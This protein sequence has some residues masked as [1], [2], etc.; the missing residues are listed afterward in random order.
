MDYR[1]ES[2]KKHA[3]WQGKIEITARVPVGSREE[4]SLAYTPGVAEPCMAIHEDVEKSFELTRRWNTVPVITDGTAVLGLGDIGPEAG[5]PVM[6]GKCALFKAYGDVDAYPLCIASKDTEEII[7]SIK[8]FAGSFGGINLEDISAPRCFEIET[9]LK[10]ELDIPVFHDDQ[11]GTAIVTAAALLNAL[12]LADK[13]I[14]E[15]KVVI[16]GAGA[17]GIAIAKFLMAF[18]VK[19]VIAC[20]SR[21][22]IVEGDT[23]FN[24]VQQELA[25]ITNREKL[26]G[27][28]ADAMKGADVLV[29]VSVANCVTKEMVRSMAEKPILFTC[30]NPVPEIH[31]D[32]AKEAGAF[33]VGTGSSQYPNQINNVLV[34]PGLFRG[35]LDVRATTVNK[36]MM[37]AASRGIADCI[38]EDELSREYIL[39]FA[40]DKRAHESVARAVAAAA[41]ETGVAKIKK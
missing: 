29:G 15:I 7:R 34:F 35:A 32:D 20:S 12:K 6:E 9:R 1:K 38:S 31:P 14:D 11:H 25:K 36:E 5:M 8:L 3:E 30:A 39:P 18:G 17:A 24:P 16:N 19:D 2:L 28:L 21:G 33:I 26:T 27:T 40:Y 41:I 37:M 10:E 4:L 22:I 23:R 13:R